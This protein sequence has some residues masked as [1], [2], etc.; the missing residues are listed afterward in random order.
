MII[1]TVFLIIGFIFLIKGAD[2]LVSGASAI[3]KKYHVSELVIGLTIVA[4][5]TSMPELVVNLLASVQ[6]SPGL[7]IG[8]VLGSNIS[9]IFLVLGAT[10]IIYPLTVKKTT[11]LGEMPFSLFTVVLFAILVNDSVFRGKIS[12]LDLTDGILLLLVF[13]V[14]IYYTFTI[15]QPDRKRTPAFLKK[16][17]ALNGNDETPFDSD[18]DIIKDLSYVKS[19][20]YVILGLIGL[21][22]G[23]NLIVGNAV[24]IAKSLGLSEFVIGVTIVA[25]GT[26]LPELVTSVVAATKKKA[27]IAVGNIVGSNIFNI[28]WILGISSVI[29]EIPFDSQNNVDIGFAFLASLLLLVFVALGKDHK[30][31]RL[32]GGVFVLL[33]FV[34]IGLQFV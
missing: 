21:T 4:F 14:F 5:G 28:L 16:F 20:A 10:A 3:A 11:V 32:E 22:Y 7:A 30:L 23:G 17:F 1:S 18:D 27:D 24:Q 6:N 9:N 26:S 15:S 25:I 29:T 13:T 31:T 19:I 12:S 33:Y 34:Y 2:F 8:N